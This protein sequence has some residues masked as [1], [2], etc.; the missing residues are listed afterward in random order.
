VLNLDPPINDIAFPY[1]R[2]TA[3]FFPW[4]DGWPARVRT[5]LPPNFHGYPDTFYFWD[6]VCYVGWLPWVACIFLLVRAIVRRRFPESPWPF[7]AVIG[8][9]ALVFALPWW[10]AMLAHLP[11]TIL[12]SPARQIYITGF[13]L[14]AALAAG[15][16]AALRLAREHP[17]RHR[18]WVCAAVAMILAL[19]GVDLG[20]Y[21]DRAFIFPVFLHTDASDREAAML[22]QAIG[23]DGRVAIDYNLLKTY[24]RQF[25]DIGF[26]DS[27]ILSRPYRALMDA[28]GAAPRINV[29]NLDGGQLLPRALELF[30]VRIVVTAH[31]PPAPLKELAS[32]GGVAVYATNHPLARASLVPLSDAVYLEPD[33]IHQ[34]LRDMSFDLASHLLLPADAPRPAAPS[35]D[36]APAGAAGVDY[37]HETSDHFVADIVAPA[38]GYLRLLET[39]DR[40]WT[41][42]LDDRATPLICAYDSLMAIAVPAGA[43]RV[44]LQFRTPGT[45]AAGGMSAVSF[46]LLLL[47]LRAARGPQ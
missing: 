24:N 46:V 26:F 33:Q 44:E 45:L 35:P 2:L 22:R 9:G 14:S 38:P 19:H 42:T 7:I 15:V 11:G 10:H 25:D 40:G 12:R 21:H 37:R 18:A 41:A 36:Q 28:T 16:D 47:L 27:V 34:R 8:I 30:G 5:P 39:W 6:T 3:F 23:A 17:G 31:S 13:A 32:S 20:V 4:Q 43:H 29:Q 1:G